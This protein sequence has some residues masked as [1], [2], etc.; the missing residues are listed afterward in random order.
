[1][2]GTK[3]TPR[4][5]KVA[6]LVPEK[7]R[8]ADIGCDHAYISI[9]LCRQQ[10][11]R[12]VIAMDVGRGPIEIAKANIHKAGLEEQ[13]EVRLS[14]GIRGLCPGEVDTLVIAGMGGALMID[15]LEGK[16][17]VLEQISVLVLQ[18]QSEIEAVRRYVRQGGFEI[19]EEDMVWD[20]GKPYF[21]FRCRRQEAADGNAM[22]HW[23]DVEYRYGRLLLRNKDKG[24]YEFLLREESMLCCIREALTGQR[25]G[26]AQKRLLEVQEQLEWNREAQSY[27][28]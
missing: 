27:Y 17:E 15:I 4:M 28:R 16:P 20:K 1:M 7:A 12:E 18:P 8:V 26:K 2:E 10:G 25:G 19:N 21:M 14:D 22:W 24:L 6:A 13:I 23:T 5:L 11:V 9:H 3:L